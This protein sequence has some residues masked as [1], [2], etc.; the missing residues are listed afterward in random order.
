MAFFNSISYT[1]SVSVK[2][3]LSYSFVDSDPQFTSLLAAEVFRY[4]CYERR[5]RSGAAGLVQPKIGMKWDPW[6]PGF[7]VTLAPF[8][9]GASAPSFIW[10]ICPFIKATSLPQNHQLCQ[11]S[12]DHSSPLLIGLQLSNA[13][14]LYH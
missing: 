2:H 1:F 7:P 14:C 5:A 6:F 10:D 4:F 13:A 8:G 11:Q 3:R 9:Q 12:P